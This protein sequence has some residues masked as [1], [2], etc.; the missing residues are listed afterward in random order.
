MR[1]WRTMKQP[2]WQ[3]ITDQRAKKRHRPRPHICARDKKTTGTRSVYRY[4]TLETLEGE[5]LLEYNNTGKYKDNI[6]QVPFEEFW[7]RW[8]HKDNNIQRKK[9]MHEVGS[10]YPSCGRRSHINLI[11]LVKQAHTGIDTMGM[12]THLAGATPSTWIQSI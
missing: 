10:P 3:Q 7:G 9:R 2:S 4:R 11:G 8:V 6:M 12:W 5:T 1:L